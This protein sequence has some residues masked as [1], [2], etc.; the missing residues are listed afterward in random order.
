MSSHSSSSHNI[1][2][3]MSSSEDAFPKDIFLQQVFLAVQNSKLFKVL[4]LFTMKNTGPPLKVSYCLWNFG[5]NLWTILHLT[6]RYENICKWPFIQLRGKKI[7][8]TYAP[9]ALTVQNTVIFLPLSQLFTG[10]ICIWPFGAN[11]FPYR[12]CPEWRFSPG[13]S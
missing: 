4:W 7:E 6:N 9:E 13:L 11:I 8:G 10:P 1:V 2:S 12:C 5:A 3:S